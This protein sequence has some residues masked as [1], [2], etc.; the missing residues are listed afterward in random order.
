MLTRPTTSAVKAGRVRR[1][2]AN[3]GNCEMSWRGRAHPDTAVTAGPACSLSSSEEERAGERRLVCELRFPLSPALSPLLRRGERELQSIAVPGCAWRGHE[4]VTDL[5][6][7]HAAT[8][9]LAKFNLQHY[10]PHQIIAPRCDRVGARAG[11]QRLGG[12]SCG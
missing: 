6:N 2:S 12:F 10:V 5:A 9:L 1:S 8:R 3:G 11:V 4:R 7:G